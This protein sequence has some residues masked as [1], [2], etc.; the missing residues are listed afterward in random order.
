MK[1]ICNILMFYL[2]SNSR[3]TGE[4]SSDA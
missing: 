4:N 1:R 2:I 3:Y